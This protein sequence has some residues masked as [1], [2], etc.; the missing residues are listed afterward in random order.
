MTL[1]KDSIH[2]APEHRCAMV[3]AA[4]VLARDRPASGAPV[5]AFSLGSAS[6]TGP[7]AIASAEVPAER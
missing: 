4:T 1:W 6:G 7:I 2:G 5:K 3:G